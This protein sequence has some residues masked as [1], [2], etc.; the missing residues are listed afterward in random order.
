MKNG[1]F[2]YT[3]NIEYTRLKIKRNKQK[4]KKQKAKKIS[5]TKP[6]MEQGAKAGAREGQEVT[7][8]QRAPAM[9]LI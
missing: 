1:Q 2:K 9:L 4:T 5:N 8:S 3:G 6:A 7:A